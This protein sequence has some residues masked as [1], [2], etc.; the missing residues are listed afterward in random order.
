MSTEDDTKQ[1]ATAQGSGEQAE[2]LDPKGAETVPLGI[3]DTIKAS[4]AEYIAEHD[5]ATEEGR[6]LNL[7]WDFI[8][9]HGGPLMAHLFTS[10]TKQLLPEN[11]NFSIPAAKKGAA[12]EGEAKAEGEGKPAGVNI[13]FDLNDFIGK[14]FQGRQGGGSDKR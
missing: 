14:L 3:A 6:Q 7:D 9:N 11:L 13:N 10:V 5:V 4:V 2:K 12:S 8:R 1:D